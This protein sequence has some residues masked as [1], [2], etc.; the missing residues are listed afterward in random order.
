MKN[1]QALQQDV[2][3]ALAW[4]PLLK[5]T[6]L[7]VTAE[8]GIVTLTGTVDSFAKKIEAENTV[9]NVAGV[10]AVVE[11]IEVK[12]YSHLAT[13][14]D[15]EIA[16]AIVTAFKWNIEI[17]EDKVQVRVEDG[18][19]TLEGSLSWNYQKEAVQK[20]VKGLFGIRGVTNSIVIKVETQD[21]IEEKI[22]LKALRR[23]ASLD[24]RK[25]AVEVLGTTITLSGTVISS[26]QKSEAGRLAWNTPGVEHVE[27]AIVVEYENAFIDCQ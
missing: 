13:R 18:W 8:G 25:I 26:Y 23:N 9:K 21:E 7:G 11:E 22:L 1:N 6:Q 3:E 17:P 4:E 15:S 24:A 27:N 16:S 19:V 10:K 5:N 2:Q 12:F 20:A 14:D